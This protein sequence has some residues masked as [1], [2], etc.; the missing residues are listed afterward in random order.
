MLVIAQGEGGF[1]PGRATG[2]HRNRTGRGHRQ[3]AGVAHRPVLSLRA[4]FAAVPFREALPHAGQLLRHGIGL[5]SDHPHDHPAELHPVGRVI[6]D[7]Q[8]HQ[9][10]RK[11]H[12]SQA[13]FPGRLGHLL[14]LVDGVGVGIDDVVQKA[15]GG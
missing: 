12:D 7:A 1:A 6:W 4:V 2:D 11:A 15:S 5:F 13:D 14:Y 9:Q 3:A 8:F 10:I